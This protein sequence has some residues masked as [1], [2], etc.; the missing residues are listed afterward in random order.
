MSSSWSSQ[1]SN[2]FGK[3]IKYL[4]GKWSLLKGNND[5]TAVPLAL[6]ICKKLENYNM[7]SE[8]DTFLKSLPSDDS[9]DTNEGIV[10]ARI[11]VA[12][13]RKDYTLVCSLIKVSGDMVCLF[14]EKTNL[15]TVSC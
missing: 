13:E 5:E 6:Q 10:R 7:Y 8:L 11:A 2:R 3:K 12:Y 9:Y 15:A 1:H 4:V 14:R